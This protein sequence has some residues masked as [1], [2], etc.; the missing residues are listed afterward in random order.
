MLQGDCYEPE[1]RLS[2]QLA[3]TSTSG[4]S[5]HSRVALISTTSQSQESPAT[6]H[7]QQYQ[8]TVWDKHPSNN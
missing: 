4:R 7:S 5:Q 6:N 3:T 8:W 2:D 1:N